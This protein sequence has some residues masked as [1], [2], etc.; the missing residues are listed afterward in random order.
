MVKLSVV[1]HAWVTQALDLL[2]TA[3]VTVGLAAI[4]ML[5]MAAT[6]GAAA[7]VVIGMAMVPVFFSSSQAAGAGGGGGGAGGDKTT[8]SWNHQPLHSHT[9]CV[10]LP[11]PSLPPSDARK[12]AVQQ[13]AWMW[14]IRHPDTRALHVGAR[15]MA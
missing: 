14:D 10:H 4:A 11:P 2:P 13:E 6:L 12:R 5:P 9:G 8:G 3:V 1:W 7:W 15:D